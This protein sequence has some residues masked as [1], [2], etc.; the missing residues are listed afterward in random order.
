MM[1]IEFDCITAIIIDDECAILLCCI[2]VSRTMFVQ[3]FFAMLLSFGEMRGQLNRK[4]NKRVDIIWL[5]IR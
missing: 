1:S 4:F 3:M 2:L 5:F